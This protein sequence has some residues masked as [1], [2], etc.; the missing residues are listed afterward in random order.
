MELRI[1]FY[2]L[3]YHP[4]N[5]LSLVSFHLRREDTKHENRRYGVTHAAAMIS[6]YKYSSTILISSPSFPFST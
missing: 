3:L 4:A 2:L 5:L 1:T 6:D